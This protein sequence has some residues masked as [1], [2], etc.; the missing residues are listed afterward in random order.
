MYVNSGV[1]WGELVCMYIL[2][3]YM[4]AYIH[5]GQLRLSSALII[6]I[7]IYTYIHTYIYTY[8]HTY[9]SMKGSLALRM[10]TKCVNLHT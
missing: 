2:H 3:T 10:Y 7:Y 5:I 4:H 1:S 9:R 8:K 6:Y